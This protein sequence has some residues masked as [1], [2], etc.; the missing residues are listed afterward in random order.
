MQTHYTKGRA[1]YAKSGQL[2]P[3]SYLTFPD[4]SKR[5][6]LRREGN[7]SAP[8]AIFLA[9]HGSVCLVQADAL[10]QMAR[11]HDIPFCVSIILAWAIRVAFL[12]GP[13]RNG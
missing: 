3:V 7:K 10:H 9:G 11:D 6:Y 4:G 1:D 5:A 12:K 2:D 13:S 8:G